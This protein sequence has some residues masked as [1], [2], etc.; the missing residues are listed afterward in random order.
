MEKYKNL[1]IEDANKYYYQS[2]ELG[3]F[4]SIKFLVENYTIDLVQEKG[5][6]KETA[7][8]YLILN[9]R[10]DILKYL[11]EEKGYEDILL[12]KLNVNPILSNEMW[13]VG[14]SG[15]IEILK[16]IVNYY[17]KIVDNK[18]II[19]S[20][21][22]VLNAASCENNLEMVKF[23]LLDKDF[24]Y[25]PKLPNFNYHAFQLATEHG[26]L[27]VMDFYLTCKELK[28]RPTATTYNNHGI[29]FAAW[30]GHLNIV[31]YL[32]TSEKIE[33][34]ADIHSRQDN[35]LYGAVMNENIEMID[36]LLTSKKI[37][38]HADIH[39]K[40]DLIFR[41]AVSKNKLSS[42][43]YLIVDFNIDITEPIEKIIKSNQQIKKMFEMRELYKKLNTNILETSVKDKKQ[44]I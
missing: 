17:E 13:S 9:K 29:R 4:E 41:K 42:L 12:N 19:Y 25:N 20:M 34:H 11:I 5:I 18:S 39:V 23:L 22:W 32:L 37:K 36:F 6:G 15:D 35:S 43:K 16:Y 2:C 40:N 14:K 3:D 7:I 26:S 30:R 8:D 44:K 24:K 38:E 10:L 27:E 31:E 33:E 1:E 28:N 21:N